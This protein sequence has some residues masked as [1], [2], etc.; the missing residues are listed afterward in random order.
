MRLVRQL[1]EDFIFHCQYEKNLSSL[2]L[3]AYKIDLEQFLNFIEKNLTSREI[4]LINNTVLKSYIKEIHE[5]YKP[6][7]IKRK[8]A[9]LKAFFNHLEFED[10]IQ[11]SPFRKIKLNIKEGKQ[12]PKTIEFE[13]I[14][15]LFTHVYKLKNSPSS[16]T[17]HKYK[18]IVRDIAVLE[19]LF[20]TGMRVSELS[21]L[22]KDDISL[23]D[24]WTKVNG[25]G[26]K[27]RYIPICNPETLSA[28][29]EYIKLFQRTID[30]TGYL[31]INRLEKRLSEQSI[32]L[33]IQKYTK[34]SCLN[35]HIT[36]H[37]FRH[38]A[39]TLLLEAGVDIRYIQIFLGHSSINTTLIYTHVNQ[40][41]HKEIMRDK[42][43][44]GR[45]RT[46]SNI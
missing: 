36:P 34:S 26:N 6:K 33:M 21:N 29:R 22:K 41:P 3:K 39:A 2:T 24:Q 10:I 40:E 31:F 42:H 12:L 17:N 9:T 15:T 20:S 1:V 16:K 7:S 38:S 30:K 5:T 8:L 37:M 13:K 32:R 35:E 27:E 23:N 43:P 46:S 18:A 11:F 28:L 44:R 19:L 4:D 45:F 14:K 25:K